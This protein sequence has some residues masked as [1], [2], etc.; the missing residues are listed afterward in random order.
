MDGPARKVRKSLVLDLWAKD[1]VN[2]QLFQEQLGDAQVSLSD[3]T[4]NQV[5]VFIVTQTI[6]WMPYYRCQMKIY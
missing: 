6:H 4:S 2:T 5:Q 1:S 3:H